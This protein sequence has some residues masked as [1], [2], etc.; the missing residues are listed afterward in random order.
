MAERTFIMI[1]PDHFGLADRILGELDR[2]ALRVQTA[3]VAEVPRDVIEEHYAVHRDRSFFGYMTSSFV[4]RSVVIAVYEG[5]HVIERFIELIGPTDPSKA[6]PGTIRGEYGN[7]SL[8][9]A[10]AEKRPCSNVIHRSDSPQEF[11]REFGVWKEYLG[12]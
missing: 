2:H 3:E 10:L 4:G 12:V 9:R 7:D 5:E 11:E 1:K 8:E 6:H